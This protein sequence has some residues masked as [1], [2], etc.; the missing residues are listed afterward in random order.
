MAQ[1][2]KTSGEMKLSTAA[3][4]LGVISLILFFVLSRDGENASG[5]TWTYAAMAAG[6]I[7]QAVSIALYAKIEKNTLVLAAVRFLQT[8]CYVL[9]L[10][11]F[12]L[13]RVNWLFRIMSKM[14]AAPLTALF[15]VV[16]VAFVVTILVHV[17][18]TYMSYEK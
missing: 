15:P 14:S 12:I 8:A 10:A 13:D 5:G 18:S 11:T 1:V 16:I 17:I 6:V 7:L 2:K 9:A 4:I 3:A